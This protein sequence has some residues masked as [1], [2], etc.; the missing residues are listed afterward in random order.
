MEQENLGT[1]IMDDV[2]LLCKLNKGFEA[3]LILLAQTRMNIEKKG[4]TNGIRNEE[5]IRNE[6]N[7]EE[8]NKV[9][10]ETKSKK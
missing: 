1:I 6:T 7:A 9:R 3:Q 2:L 10:S 5:V 4:N 8:T